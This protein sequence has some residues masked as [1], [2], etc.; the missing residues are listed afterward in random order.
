MSADMAPGSC[1]VRA[2][3]KCSRGSLAFQT[4]K[5][6]TCGPTGVVTRN[7]CPAGTFHALPV[8]IGTSNCLINV[9]W[10]F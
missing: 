6:P 8:R 10:V 1:R 9:R 2:A 3:H 4:L 5:S 7:T